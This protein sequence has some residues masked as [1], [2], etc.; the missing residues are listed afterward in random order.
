LSKGSGPRQLGPGL[1]PGRLSKR[2]SGA[3]SS[4]RRQ[5]PYLSIRS[6]GKVARAMGL[7]GWLRQGLRTRDGMREGPRGIGPMRK[8]RG[9]VP[10][11]RS[12]RGLMMKSRDRMRNNK[13]PSTI[14][15]SHMK[16]RENTKIN[17]ALT[18]SIKP[19]VNLTNQDP[20]SVPND[21]MKIPINNRGKSH[22][23]EINGMK[24][25]SSSKGLS[26]MMRGQQ[27]SL[28]TEGKEA[29]GSMRWPSIV[30]V[31]TIGGIPRATPQ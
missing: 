6:R 24:I 15:K 21:P 1:K 7:C 19:T 27:K 5:G 23:N 10:M 2:S 12:N 8:G 25:S 9:I 17:N 11:K 26:T 13:D 30:R 4:S 20:A 29:N 16:S 14:N 22:M 3:S 28:R 18:K 31:M